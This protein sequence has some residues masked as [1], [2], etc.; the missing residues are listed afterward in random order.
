MFEN[1]FVGTSG[2]FFGGSSVNSFPSDPFRVSFR[3]LND[4]RPPRAR[5]TI[6]SGLP[7]KAIVSLLPSLRPG[8]FRLNEVTIVFGS[9]GFISGLFHCPMHGPQA[10]A[11]T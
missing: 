9:P 10:L 5:A 1:P 6:N 11:N 3:G 4:S 2:A 8:K 7:I